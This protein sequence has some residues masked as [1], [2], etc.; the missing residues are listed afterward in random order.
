MRYGPLAALRHRSPVHGLDR[1]NLGPAEVIAQSVSCAAPAAGMATVPAIVATS[2]GSATVWSFVLATVLA[3]LV[4]ACIGSFTRRMAAAGS[5]YSLTSKGLPPGAAFASCAAIVAG[6]LVLVMAALTGAS[7]Y[8]DALMARFGWAAPPAV[9]AAAALAL[10]A[11]AGALV[12]RGVRLS[13]R[14]VL[15]VE[16]VSIALML[17]IFAVLLATATPA[18]PGGAAEPGLAGVAAGVLPALGAFIGFEAATTLGVEARRPFS[19]VPRAVLGTAAVVGLLSIVAAVT[20]VRGFDGGLGGQPEPVVTLAAAHGT[21]WL[22]VLLDA[23][24]TTS[25]VACTLATTNALVRVLFSMGRDKIVPRALGRTHARYRTP[26]IAIAVAL[27]VAA[28][29]PAALLGAGTPGQD[30]LRILL[31]IATAGFLVGYLLVCLAA[32]LFLRRIGELTPGPVIIT[33]VTVP[34]LAA[35]CIA[36]LLSALDGPVPVVLAGLLAAVLGWYVWLRL[37]HPDRLAAIG[38]YDE[39]SAAD[40]HPARV[41]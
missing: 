21:S 15:A 35:T 39:T 23:G 36:F 31:T 22:A 10:A 27:P 20:Q 24:I 19:S 3:V 30:V 7:I 29:V 13:A 1:R 9:G 38:V 37:R 16:A 5:L 41:P 11:V 4:A 8:F 2:A 26:H 34:A 14:T 33:A 17:V 25:F 6:Y 32:P 28:A 40:V 18:P 12:L